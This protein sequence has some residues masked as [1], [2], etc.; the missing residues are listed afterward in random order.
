MKHVRCWFCALILIASFAPAG[1][2]EP[3]SLSVDNDVLSSLDTM[4]IVNLLDSLF[5][6][7][8]ELHS[9]MALRVG[10]N[11][12]VLSA[13]RTLGINNFG[14][15][16]AVS[17]YHKSG[18]YADVAAYWSKDFEPAYYLTVAAAG[19]MRDIS[20]HFSFALEY[21]RYFYNKSNGYTYIPYENV[22]S[23]TPVIEFKPVSLAI[24]YAYYF[25]EQTAHRIMPGLTVTLE[26]KKVW[27]F[28][29]ISL[30][31]SFY[32]LWGNET[33]TTFEYLVPSTLREARE[34]YQKYGTI[35]G[36]RQIDEVVYGIMNYTFSL[37]LSVTYKK[38]S[39]ILNY[40]YNVPVQ[41]NDE[42]LTIS[43]S[44]Y[45]S[46]SLNYFIDLKPRKKRL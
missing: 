25:G 7:D 3:D 38:W 26:K 42:P 32:V 23:L 16:P 27:I 35:M 6:L 1:A 19:Y 15:A 30:L 4:S 20:K 31:P 36:I 5:E 44:S 10:Y 39:L 29:K 43:E 41:L 17:Y 22:M 13:G 24:N 2:Q 37:P 45:L 33:I 11:S 18:L 40:A 12:N 8:L 21:D 46:G 14:L 34:N 28:D 9:E